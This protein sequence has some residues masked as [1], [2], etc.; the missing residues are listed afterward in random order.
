MLI[1]KHT[2]P[3]MHAA[4]ASLVSTERGHF[5]LESGLHG[6]L[7]M[8]LEGL[9]LKPALI[10]P[11]AAELAQRVARYDV[12]VVCGPLVEGAFLA[13][14]VARQLDLPFTYSERYARTDAQALYPYGYAVPR[15][16]HR[17][18]R[19]R[20]V[21]VINDVIGGGSAV[22]GTWSALEALGAQPVLIGALLVAGPWT[23]RFAAEKQIAVESLDSI[24][25][26]LWAPEECPLCARGEPL[27]RRIQAT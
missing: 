8:D 21:A 12:D 16:L 18:L 7:W 22:G 17:H 4:I 26:E 1:P 5:L 2:I 23:S 6:N 14:M 9:F 11:L 10:E 15:L 19:G 13:L 25:N 3:C 20:R 24:E 27:V